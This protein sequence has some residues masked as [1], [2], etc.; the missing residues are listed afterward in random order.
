[1]QLESRE[2]A[3]EV[4][5]V[6]SDEAVGEFRE[7]L[8]DAAERLFAQRGLDA[9]TLRQLAAEVGVSPMTPYRYFADKTA[10]LAAVRA[11]AFR[12]HAEALEAAFVL[13]ESDPVGQAGAVPR[14]Y[15]DFAFAHPE[16][17]KLMFDI[18]QPDE[19]DYPELV[20]AAER[21]RRTMT[22]GLEALAAAGLFQGDPG[23][24]GHMY[25]AALHGPIMLAFS[26]KLMGGY[27][28]RQVVEALMRAL[29]RGVFGGALSY[30]APSDQGERPG[31]PPSLTEPG[32][33]A[34]ASAASTRSIR[35]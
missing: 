22:R 3:G 26:G 18:T 34:A 7:R 35:K 23:L 5:R 16:A 1:L 25:W 24:V 14:A 21:S 28:A 30:G 27:T 32:R 29:D 15:V 2:G 8:I 13:V 31:G 33:S 6:L 11:R 20:A 4:P 17:Y 10:I 19:A 12:R 9:V